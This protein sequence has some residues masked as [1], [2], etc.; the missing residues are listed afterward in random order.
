M[1]P[2]PLSPAAAASPCA[3]PRH[4]G[5]NSSSRS[6][7]LCR[8][9][10]RRVAR[11]SSQ[12]AREIGDLL[13]HDPV[14][15]AAVSPERAQLGGAGAG[16]SGAVSA[17]VSVTDVQLSPDLQFAR[18]LVSVYSDEKGR[19]RAMAA[20]SRLQPYVRARVAERVRLRLAPEL[21]FAYDDELERSE[22]VLRALGRGQVARLL[23][24]EAA[25]EAFG[26]RASKKD[27]LQQQQQQ[28]GGQD[29]E[30]EGFFEG[31]GAA[32]GGKDGD[33]AAA[34]EGDGND[35]SDKDDDEE[36]E[37]D[38]EDA[39]AAEED[40]RRWRDDDPAARAADF[41]ATPGPFDDMFGGGD[42]GG[43][44]SVSGPL[45][46]RRGAGGGGRGGGKGRG[47]NGERR[48]SK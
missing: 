34:G 33:R 38:E 46:P 18:V 25:G 31:V 11:V 17:L 39:A 37:E 2:S 6:C 42:G 4:N 47:G 48:R 1:A 41:L 40:E 9:H 44:R 15:S 28:E 30:E 45:P 27:G 13:S 21:R 32:A 20:L 5:R 14:V 3:A 26:N 12:I 22:S 23:G 43:W 10:P 19:R 7:L 35:S 29:E 8:A 16:A 36:E 24:E